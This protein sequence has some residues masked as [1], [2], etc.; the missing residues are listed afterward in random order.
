VNDGR[1]LSLHDGENGDV[2]VHTYQDVEPI[3]DAAK[4]ERR[5]N[6]ELGHF[7][8]KAEFR[9]KMTIPF[10]VMQKVCQETGL[11]FYNPDDAKA[12]AKIFAGVEYKAFRTVSDKNI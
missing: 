3:L 8:K 4:A 11:D 7:S 10:N 2:I 6:D 12:L 1:R 5:W 9:K